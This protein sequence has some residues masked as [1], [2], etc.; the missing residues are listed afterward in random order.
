MKCLIF[1]CRSSSGPEN[2]A[3][4]QQLLLPAPPAPNG[5][6]T[7][8]AKME[9]HIDLLSDDFFTPQ[10]DNSLAL[11]PVS[12]P[13]TIISPPS[14]QQNILALADMFS[15]DNSA[16]ASLVAQSVHSTPLYPSTPQSQ[17]QKQPLQPQEPVIYSNG[18]MQNTA[19][20][21]YE[22]TPYMQTA[23]S[24]PESDSSWNAQSL[25]PQQQALVY[26]IYLFQII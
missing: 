2:Q 13:P 22:Q 9:P 6:A 24:N 23:D 10:A 3:P 26:G 12:Q 8:S 5:P 7:P 19:Q 4:L 17:P 18:S 15:L 25:D 1:I 21:Q 11:V 20:P 14:N 16:P